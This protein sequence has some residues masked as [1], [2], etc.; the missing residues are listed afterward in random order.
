MQ[1]DEPER[2]DHGALA[3]TASLHCA[4]TD[5]VAHGFL[6]ARFAQRQVPD[7]HSWST[8]L[9][10]LF[11]HHPS[12]PSTPNT[13]SLYWPVTHTLMVER[14]TVSSDHLACHAWLHITHCP[15]G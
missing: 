10:R 1:R 7:N 12:H 3:A 13:H 11:L 9:A 4:L 15:H 14:P 8:K 5:G 6:G 2:C